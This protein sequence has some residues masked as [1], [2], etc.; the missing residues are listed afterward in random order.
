[1]LLYLYDMKNGYLQ[2]KL[3]ISDETDSTVL[4]CNDKYMEKERPWPSLY[5]TDWHR[6]ALIDEYQALWHYVIIYLPPVRITDP[7]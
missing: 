3:W 4:A 7:L 6:R 5:E 1:M 2:G